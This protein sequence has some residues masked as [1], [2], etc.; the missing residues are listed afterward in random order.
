MSPRRKKTYLTV[1]ALGGVALLVDRLIPSS[2][3]TLPQV[4]VARGAAPSVKPNTTGRNVAE[5]DATWSIPEL[6]FPHGLSVYQAGAVFRDLFAPPGLQWPGKTGDDAADKAD[7]SRNAEATRPATA[8]SF[9]EHHRL[10][11][12]I[13]IQHLTI[14]VVDGTWLHVGETLDGCVVTAIHDNE[15]LFRCRDGDTSLKV[16]ASTGQPGS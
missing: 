4:A 16:I 14:A 8:A 6:P 3:A 13:L 7:S 10:S 2:S 15:A 1:I 9:A 11:G 5:S 12:V